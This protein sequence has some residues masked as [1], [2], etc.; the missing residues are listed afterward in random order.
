MST[1]GKEKPIW[2]GFLDGAK[3]LKLGEMGPY[4][5]KYSR[6]HLSSNQLQSRFDRAFA[7]RPLP[8]CDIIKTFVCD[9]C[10]TSTPRP[11]VFSRK[12][13][14]PGL[15]IMLILK[16]ICNYMYA[17]LVWKQSF[18]CENFK[19]ASLYH[20]SIQWKGPSLEDKPVRIG[21]IL[22]SFWMLVISN[23]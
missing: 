21:R 7:V 9:L 18:S 13:A 16:G 5:A 23:M 2:R 10:F 15:V 22:D 8:F 14:S 19:I 3:G 20:A 1:G 17:L 11:F 12:S 6:E 4:A